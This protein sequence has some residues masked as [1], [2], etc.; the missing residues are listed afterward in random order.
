MKEMPRCNTWACFD[1]V[2]RTSK[3]VD[4]GHYK[5]AEAKCDHCLQLYWVIEREYKMV[6]YDRKEGEE[7]VDHRREER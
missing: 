2:I 6:I 7:F 4:N 5:Y 1:R 3:W